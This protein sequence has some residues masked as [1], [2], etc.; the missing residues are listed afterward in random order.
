MKGVDG[1]REALNELGPRDICVAS[2]SSVERIRASLRIVGFSRLFE[3]NLF[4]ATEVA[5]GKPAPDLFLL[6]AERM[7]ADP[8]D[9]LVIEDSVP[10]VT[11]AARAGM[12]VFGYVGGG[13]I[14][15]V[16]HGERLRAAGAELAFDD[17]RELPRLIRRQRVLRPASEWTTGKGLGNG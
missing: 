15:G 11:A 4:S 2:S 3:P 5:N 17:M 8:S 10:G 6:A 9:C 12:A 16:A 14:V 13:H 7:G 1:I